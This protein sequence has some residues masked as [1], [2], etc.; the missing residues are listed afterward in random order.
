MIFHGCGGGE[1]GGRRLWELCFGNSAWIWELSLDLGTLLWEL[2]KGWI[3][4]LSWI[5]ELARRLR[6]LIRKPGFGNSEKG[7]ALGTL[8]ET[9]IWELPGSLALGTPP[10]LGT[11]PP[12]GFG[13]SAGFGNLCG[14]SKGS[15]VLLPWL[16]WPGLG[17]AGVGSGGV[18]W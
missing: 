11:L 8:P 7:L 6:E 12:A 14:N 5:W 15:L 1:R 3:W 10:A 16:G 17:L 2:C 9:W 4:E 13:N 18:G